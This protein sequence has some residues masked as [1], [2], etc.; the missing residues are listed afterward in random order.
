MVKKRHCNVQRLDSKIMEN[1]GLENNTSCDLFRCPHICIKKTQ[2]QQQRWQQQKIC[3]K[4]RGEGQRSKIIFNFNLI[5]S[6]D[7]ESPSFGFTCP[8]HINS[9]ADKERNYTQVSWPPVIATDNS[10]LA[11]TVTSRGVQV[12]YYNGKHEVTY[13]ASDVAGNF[14][15]C[16]FH[17]TVESKLF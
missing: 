6:A 14:K 12:I 4:K 8:S 15:I 5:L 10:G 3:Q 16:K 17:I 7:V 13:N 1:F 2:S 11:P 9:Y